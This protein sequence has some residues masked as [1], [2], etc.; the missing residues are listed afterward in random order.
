MLNKKNYIFTLLVIFAALTVITGCHHHFR[1]GKHISSEKKAAVIHKIISKKLDLDRKQRQE[2]ERIQN[3]IVA[4]HRE[5]FNQNQ[6]VLDEMTDIVKADTIDRQKLN[7]VLEA[8]RGKV[9]PMHEFM[10]EKFIEFHSILTPKQR[11][12][13]AVEMEKFHKRHFS[14]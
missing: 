12:R 14:E 3:E 5:H 13:L 11:N 4:K 10:V 9:V 8:R 7:R 6:D 2:L 1:H